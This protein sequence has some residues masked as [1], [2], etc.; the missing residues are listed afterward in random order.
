MGTRAGAVA[1]QEMSVRLSL[2][3]VGENWKVSGFS[4]AN[5]L[6]GA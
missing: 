6:P 1:D 5:G 2:Q 4:N 3:K